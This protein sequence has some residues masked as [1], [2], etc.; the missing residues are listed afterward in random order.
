[1]K[2]YNIEGNIDFFTELY[3]SLDVV[4]NEQKTSEDD[5]LCLITCQPLTENHVKMV[6]GHKF[7]YIPLYNDIKNHKQKFNNLEGNLS[8]LKYNEIRCPYCRNKQSEL[9]PYYEELELAKIHGVNFIDPNRKI[10]TCNHNN[11]K[12]CEYLI[13]NPAYD[14]SGNNPIEK[15]TKYS[16]QN[17]KFFTC[18]H[19]GYYKLS[20]Y[21]EQYNGEDKCLCHLHKQIM[22]KE[23]NKKIKD[24]AKEEAKKAKEEAKK[25]QK[26]AIL[27]AKED[28]K[29]EAKK[30]KEETKKLQKEIFI[31]V[32]EDKKTKVK[33]EIKVKEIK[34]TEI[35]VTSEN[36]VLGPVII[37]NPSNENGQP[38]G[39]IEILKSGPKKGTPCGSKIFNTDKCKR[40][41]KQQPIQEIKL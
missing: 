38:N 28:A 17:C 15:A 19:N 29:L 6:C 12:P 2:S 33:K 35:K 9:L 30:I 20:N 24:K 18:Y 21:I 7:N 23:H 8:Q 39:C 37:T 13:P 5:N 40:H 3:N 1:M 32:Q 11:R 26:E 34:V 14:P 10:S 36:V 16:N 41:F 27:K 4:E 31:K 22:V 25:L